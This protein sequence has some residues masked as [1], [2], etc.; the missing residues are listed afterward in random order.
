MENYYA[1]VY[2]FVMYLDD[3][4]VIVF[5]VHMVRSASLNECN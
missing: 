1:H 3:L 2:V 4:Y 5:T